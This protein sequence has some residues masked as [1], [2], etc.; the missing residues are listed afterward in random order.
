MCYQPRSVPKTINKDVLCRIKPEHSS[1]KIRSAYARTPRPLRPSPPRSLHATSQTAGSSNTTSCCQIQHHHDGRDT[2]RRK[3]STINPYR[4][5]LH[6]R[7]LSASPDLATLQR[8]GPI[9][10][11]QVCRAT[12]ITVSCTTAC[13]I[14]NGNVTFTQCR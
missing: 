7:H 11:V 4:A 8:L 10:L 5:Y 12:A 6:C 1:S 9:F 13:V 2:L 14:E 3:M